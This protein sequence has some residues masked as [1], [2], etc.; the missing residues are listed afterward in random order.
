[1]TSQNFP[2]YPSY[3][4]P[5]IDIGNGTTAIPF[6]S[7]ELSNNPY[8]TPLTPICATPECSNPNRANN[9]LKS[10]FYVYGAILSGSPSLQY[11]STPTKL[12]NKWLCK[13]HTES[14]EC[15]YDSCH[16]WC[17]G[18]WGSD[19]DPKAYTCDYENNWLLDNNSLS[20]PTNCFTCAFTQDPSIQGVSCTGGTGALVSQW[21]GIPGSKPCNLYCPNLNQTLSYPKINGQ[22][23]GT[24]QDPQG[25]ASGS[26][27]KMINL[28]KNSP[29]VCE[30][31][32]AA[33]SYPIKKNLLGG[34]AGIFPGCPGNPE[35]VQKYDLCQAEITESSTINC[36]NLSTQ[37]TFR[38]NY[39]FPSSC[40]L[41]SSGVGKCYQPQQ[42][43]LSPDYSGDT[44]LLQP[45]TTGAPENWSPKYVDDTATT[46]TTD[47]SGAIQCAYG[48]PV[49]MFQLLLTG[50]KHDLWMKN[51]NWTSKENPG[52]VASFINSIVKGGKS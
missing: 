47:N 13:G 23:T 19:W 52:Q 10:N 31:D 46:P 3:F 9:F 20:N 11:N 28:S 50:T 12:Q 15:P 42:N 45:S 22:P 6:T 5:R 27:Q 26:V 38:D 8:K 4:H 41:G 18:N 21:I 34:C 1:M 30:E 51:F 49:G 40:T 25:V 7:A 2:D 39:N 43:N 37:N 35:D 36:G 48:A 44:C 33:D 32:C 24:P 29:Y 16:F 17:N 14:K